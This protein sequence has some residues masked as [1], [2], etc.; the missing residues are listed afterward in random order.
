LFLTQVNVGD[1]FVSASGSS[2]IVRS[3]GSNTTLTCAARTL[4]GTAVSSAQ[5]VT[6]TGT[7]FQTEVTV[8]DILTSASGGVCQVTV[9]GS[10]TVITCLAS[11]SPVFAGAVTTPSPFP[12]FAGTY[13]TTLANTL[14]PNY[15]ASVP[16]DPRG[17]GATICATAADCSTPGVGITTLG[18]TNTGYYVHRTAGN[19]LEIGACAGE[20]LT[21]P[22]AINVKR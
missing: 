9:I 15:I 5:T 1:T 3:V 16:I 7:K 6:G 19:R 2:C 4:T 17:S 22:G 11:P 20:Q 10:D 18:T 13:T 8:G 21:G 12:P 14:T